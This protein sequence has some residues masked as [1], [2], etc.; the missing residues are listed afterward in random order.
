MTTAA[1]PGRSRRYLLAAAVALPAA[2]A[3][4]TFL[5]SSPATADTDIAVVQPWTPIVLAAHVLPDGNTPHA[6]IVRIAGT[7]FLQMRGGITCEK[8]YEFNGGSTPE[9]N[10]LL[11]TL[12]AALRPTTDYVRGVAPRNNESGSSSCQVEVNLAGE[13]HVFGALKTNKIAWVRLDSFSAIRH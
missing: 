2:A 8:G 1:P 13:I 12:P 6:R 3:G 4:A 11:G 5:G 10:D 7:E 9:T